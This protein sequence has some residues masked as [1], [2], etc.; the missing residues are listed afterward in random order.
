[1]QFDRRVQIRVRKSGTEKRGFGSGYLVAPRLVLTAAH[2]LDGMSS[3]GQGAVTVSRPDADEGE[4]PA[5]VCW[6]RTDGVVDAALIEVDGGHGWHTPESL[7]DLHARPPQRF[8]H[9][10]GT[11]PHPVTVAGFPRMQKDPDGRRLDEQLTGHILPGTGSL[12]GRYEISSTAPTLPVGP[13]S[14]PGSRWSGMSG[15]VVLS[16]TPW[17]GELLCG[18]IRR[19]RQADGGTRL[20]ATPAAH[21]LADEDF[22]A[23]ITRHTGWEPFLE[24]AEAA[25]LFAPAASERDL[26]SPA[27][28]LRADAEAVTFHGRESELATLRTW[29]ET[30]PASLLVQVLTGSGGQ[31]KTRLARR[32]TEILSHQGWATG[33]LRSDLTDHDRQPPD[34]SQLASTLP[35]LVVVDYAETRPRLVRDLITQ[36]HRFR[37][38]VRLLLLARSDGEWRT[39][40]LNAAPAARSLLSTAVITPLD[41][42]IP[43]NHPYQE[44]LGAFTRAAQDL[45]RLLPWVP[46]VPSHDW[47]ALAAALQPPDDLSHPRYD[48]ALTLQLTALATLLQHGPAPADTAPGA[49]AEE[50]LLLHEERFWKDSAEAPAFRLNLPTPTLTAAVAVAA[51]CGAASKEEAAGVISKIPDLPVDKAAR[52]AAWLATLFPAEPDRYWGSLQPDRVAEYHASRA[53]AHGSILLPPLLSTATPGQQAQLI[54]VLTRAVIAHYNASRTTDS[55]HLLHTVNTALDASP[56]AYQAVQTAAAALPYPSGITAPLALRLSTALAEADRQVA[57]DNPAYSPN[58]A[59]SLFNLGRRFAEVGRR[60]EALTTTEQAVAIYRQL[61]AG[62][63]ETYE[64]NFAAMLGNLSNRLAEVGRQAEALT[65]SEEAVAV[66]RRLAA[67]DPDTHEPN[68]AALLGTLGTRLAGVGRRAEALVTTEQAMAIYRRLAADNPDTHEPDLAASLGDLGTRLAEV[69]RRAEALTTTEQAVE[70]Y[71]RLAAYNPDAHEPNLAALLS[72]L[73][74]RFAEVG[75]RAEALTTTEQAVEVYRRL[76]AYNPDAHEPKLAA[77]LSDLGRRFAEMGRRA[78]ALT[79]TEQAV[80]AYRRL[81]VD[82]SAAQPDLAV[83]LSNLGTRLAEVGRQAE[84]LTATEEAVAIYRRLAADDPDTHEP[85]FAASL[86]N[87]GTRLA[88][89]GRQAEALTATEEAVAIYRRLAADDPDTH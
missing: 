23:L 17:G 24:P 76:A 65:A 55:N 8:G 22:Q 83:L 13:S 62:H 72:E 85:N 14:G 57:Q 5:T 43:Q 44:R 32:L 80:D 70:V 87:L 3:T 27:A 2:V 18:V 46:T 9:L 86:G 37:H 39:D 63:P 61:A 84:A 6:R 38:R 12:A 45:A 51:L 52:T 67:D 53:L 36:L 81:A 15:A 35:L 19:D 48:N 68:L 77:S 29:C 56:L 25:G 47:T 33:H 34:L 26:N 79:T 89:V 21:L 54:I 7:A 20:T 16:D 69:G 11:R 60:A 88:E 31:G 58:L 78:E 71:R 75:R 41:P 73:G 1:M 49:P 74:S 59:G 28:L 40:A 66:Y 82:H 4:F 30:G 64:P 50:I 10:I 42:L